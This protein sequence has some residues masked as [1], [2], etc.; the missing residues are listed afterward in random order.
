MTDIPPKTQVIEHENGLVTMSAHAGD[1]IM[2]RPCPC[3]RDVLLFHF[4]G[5][6]YVGKINLECSGNSTDD[7][8]IALDIYKEVESAADVQAFIDTWNRPRKVYPS[9][10]TDEHYAARYQDLA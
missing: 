9:T 10:R 8:P 5:E 4:Y 7:C 6:D 3:G 1:D 2:M